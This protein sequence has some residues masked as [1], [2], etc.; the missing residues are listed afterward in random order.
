MTMLKNLTHC[1]LAYNNFTGESHASVFENLPRLVALNLTNNQ[2]YGPVGKLG[3]ISTIQY[4]G[5]AGNQFNALPDD[6]GPAPKL[7]EFHLQH[8]KIR[9][10]LPSDFFWEM[11]DLTLLDAS[12][13]ALSGELP[14][15]LGQ[16]ASKL[17]TLKLSTNGFK[18]GMPDTIGRLVSAET[19]EIDDNFLDGTLTTAIGRLETLKRLNLSKNKMVGKIPTEISKMSSIE[20]LYLNNNLLSGT[21]PAE[22][23][24]LFMLHTLDISSTNLFANMDEALCSSRPADFGVPLSSLKADCLK[25]DVIVSC[26]TECCDGKEYCCDMTIDAECE[27]TNN[28]R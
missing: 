3:Q 20:E 14:S 8:N 1:D 6:F 2:L 28:D 24:N 21:V 9:G 25:T 16:I 11:T 15:S 27:L 12:D 26:A 13:N 5:L 22:M 17:S 10:T 19:I 23:S 4:L 7:T 18:G